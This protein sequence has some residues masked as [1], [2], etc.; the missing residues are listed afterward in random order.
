MTILPTTNA[1]EYAPR[2]MFKGRAA[3]A[4]AKNRIRYATIVTDLGLCLGNGLIE[5]GETRYG[6]MI[7]VCICNQ[8]V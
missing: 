2:L 1:G 7:R 6:N 5:C 8:D 3:A 4:P